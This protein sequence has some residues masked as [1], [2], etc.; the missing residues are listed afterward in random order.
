MANQTNDYV[1]TEKYNK[2]QPK[3]LSVGYKT[4]QNRAIQ[5]RLGYPKIKN[6]EGDNKIVMLSLCDGH[7]DLGGEFAEFALKEFYQFFE[8]LPTLC[9]YWKL[10][11]WENYLNNLFKN[12]H[13]TIVDYM[14]TNYGKFLHGGTTAT[15]CFFLETIEGFRIIS[16]NVGDSRCYMG[17]SNNYIINLSLDHKP[18]PSKIAHINT[19][20]ENLVSFSKDGNYIMAP[21][22]EGLAMDRSLGDPIL[23]NLIL[24]ASCI[25][26][27]HEYNYFDRKKLSPN[28]SIY[29]VL[30]SDGVSDLISN[31]EIIDILY[32]NEID[33]PYFDESRDLKEVINSIMLVVENRGQVLGNMKDD[34][35]ILVL[36]IY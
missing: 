16:A 5:D 6:L 9:I 23:H 30:V 20:I 29:I 21:T 25:P 35:S 13:K 15:I 34:A 28:N 19:Y 10:D 2:I 31:D 11:K 8:W 32:Q 27:I 26:S 4:Q 36:N 3:N 12:I 33:N 1:F 24:G 17:F 18:D 14:V 7:G 22:G